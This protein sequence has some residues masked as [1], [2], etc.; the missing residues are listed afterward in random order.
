MKPSWRALVSLLPLCIGCAGPTT[1]LVNKELANPTVVPL[2]DADYVWEEV[3]DV[4]DDYFRIASE[5]RV[6]LIG[7]TL[8]EGRIDTFPEVGATLFE[9]WRR[10]SANAYERLESTLQSIRRRALI[11]VIPSPSGYMIDVAVFKELEDLPRPERATT[12]GST[13]RNEQSLSRFNEPVGPQPLTLGWIPQGRDM[14][15]EQKI[16]C[17][18]NARFGGNVGFPMIPFMQA[19][20][21][22][23][24]QP[25]V[26]A[27]P[28]AVE[29]P[30]Q[31]LPPPAM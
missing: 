8:T 19:P 6:K 15:L 27:P 16:I 12:G 24:P 1:H 5:N 9:P 14:V 3:V 30:R 11:R 26:V 2:T 4:V 7:N 10:D 28:A 13:F 23:A 22:A 29:P 21:G 25:E 17:K 31:L 20:T 18:L